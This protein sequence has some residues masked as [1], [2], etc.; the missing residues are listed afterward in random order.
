MTAPPVTGGRTVLLTGGLGGAHLA[1]ALA[2]ALGP[3]RLTVVVN[4][5]DDLDWHGLRVCPDL[6]TVLY[7]LSGR[8]DAERGWGV[9]DETFVVRSA[10]QALGEPAWFGVGDR[11]LATHLVRTELLRAGHTLTEVVAALAGRAW[12]SDPLVV[13]AADIPCPTHIELADGRRTGFQEWY[14]G[15]GAAVPVRAAEPASGPAAGAALAAVAAADAVVLGPSNPVTSIGTILALDGMAEAVARAGLVVAVSPSVGGVPPTGAVA[16]HARARR[17]LLAASGDEDSAAGVAGH[18]ARCF[19]GLVDT[20]VLD[21]AD[22]SLAAEVAATGMRPV[23]ARVLDPRGL[24][25][26][27]AAA[28]SENCPTAR[29]RRAVRRRLTG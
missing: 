27:V 18:Y 20:F 24:A 7:S 12:V 22:A 10:L 19:P 29:P 14:V 21:A 28:C 11:D 25:R 6:D 15:M 23:L 4:V 17:E 13:P 3:G 2:R 5:G 8:L 16:H 1:P 9:V 26:T